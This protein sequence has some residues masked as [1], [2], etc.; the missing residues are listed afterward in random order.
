MLIVSSEKS[1]IKVAKVEERRQML[2]NPLPEEFIKGL[3]I[4][5]ELEAADLKHIL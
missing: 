4:I 2:S 5:E 3:H 1:K